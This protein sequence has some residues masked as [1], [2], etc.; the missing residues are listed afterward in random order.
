MNNNGDDE[1]RVMMRVE[2]GNF[3]VDVVI[4]MGPDDTSSSRL[5]GSCSPAMSSISLT[6]CCHI[7]LTIASPKLRLRSE[8]SPPFEMTW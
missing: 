8:H 5:F 1:R 4:N 3:E 7:I 2:E 6:R